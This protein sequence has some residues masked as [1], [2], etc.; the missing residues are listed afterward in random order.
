MVAVDGSNG[1]WHNDTEDRCCIL[2]LFYFTTLPN[3]SWKAQETQRFMVIVAVVT[4]LVAKGKMLNKNKIVKCFTSS[5]P[6]VLLLAI[7]ISFLLLDAN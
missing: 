1:A 4:F 2:L 6:L 5:L 3:K 7:Q